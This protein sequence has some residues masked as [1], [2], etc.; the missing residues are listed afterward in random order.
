ML[1]PQLKKQVGE[2][3][4]AVAVMG[5]LQLAVFFV[6]GR[7]VSVGFL[8]AFLGTLVG[9]LLAS[10]NIILL[11]RNIEKSVDKNEKGAQYSM[12]LGYM[13]RLA[14]TAVVIFAAIKLP[15]LVN[16]WAVIIPLIFPRIAI[17]VINLKFK[18][19]GDGNS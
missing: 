8:S 18:K 4:A 5:F 12:S 14:L 17:M 15:Q 6:V 13:L 3:L 11:A 2:I 16:L 7:F 9:C 10:L 19:Q 1:N